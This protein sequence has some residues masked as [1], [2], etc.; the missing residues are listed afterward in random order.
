MTKEKPKLIDLIEAFED[1]LRHAND[2][3]LRKFDEVFGDIAIPTNQ[4]RDFIHSMY[5][6]VRQE[7][8]Y[9]QQLGKLNKHG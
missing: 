1:I 3:E 8:G 5:S 6:S 2:R 4:T 7:I 9:R